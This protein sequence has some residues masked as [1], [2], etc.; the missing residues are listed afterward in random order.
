MIDFLLTNAR[1]TGQPH[2][3]KTQV[4]KSQVGYNS[5]SQLWTE[6]CSFF[7]QAS[8]SWSLLPDSIHHASS[9]H[10]LH[11]FREN[12]SFH[13]ILF[14]SDPLPRDTLSCVCARTRVVFVHLNPNILTSPPQKKKKKERER[15]VL[16]PFYIPW[17]LNT[18]PEERPGMSDVSPQSGISGPS[19]DSTLISPLL[20]FCRVLLLFPSFFLPAGSFF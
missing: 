4:A 15:E 2:R 1:S 8:T 20:F 9:G 13:R 17:A 11:N 14:F 3:A 5:G 16:K 7:C 6:Q 12:L 19:F 10:F 18:S